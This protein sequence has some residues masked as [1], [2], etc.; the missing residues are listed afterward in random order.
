MARY[1][2]YVG[3]ATDVEAYP[4]VWEEQISEHEYF[5]DVLKNRINMQQGNVINAKITIS[6]SISIIADPFAFEHVYAMRYVT[7]LGKKW[8][9]VNVSIERPRLILTLG[10]LYNE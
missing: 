8:S 2:G 10:G 6:N 5:G 4:G 9:I 1:H 7:Y 3:Y